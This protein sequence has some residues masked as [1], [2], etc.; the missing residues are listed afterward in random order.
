[1]E[2]KDLLIPISFVFEIFL[3]WIIF[4][5]SKKRKIPLYSLNHHFIAKT[6]VG[7]TMPIK[8][9]NLKKKMKAQRKANRKLEKES[10]NVIQPPPPQ[11]PSEDFV[12]S[13][14]INS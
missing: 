13:E 5:K 9:T 7:T 1:M 3:L 12:I 2:L 11:R 4:R 8:K 10:K 14:H 6:Y